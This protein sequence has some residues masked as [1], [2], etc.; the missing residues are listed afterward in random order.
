MET[1]HTIGVIG[2]GVMGSGMALNLARHGHTVLGYSRSMHKVEALASCGIRSASLD[3][4][5]ARC[6]VVLLSLTDGAAVHSVLFGE[7]GLAPN[8]KR[9][10][11]LIDTTTIAPSEALAA[12]EKAAEYDL[13]FID[14]PVTGGDVGARNGTLTIM[15][16]GTK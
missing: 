1:H 3:E 14:A 13:T 10:T 4:I 9:G 5:A 15:C 12:H 6:E 7:S 2:F 8:L 11:L 16:G